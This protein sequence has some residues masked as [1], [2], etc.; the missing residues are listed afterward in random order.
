M[1][2]V[3]KAYDTR[4]ERD[5]AVKVIREAEAPISQTILDLVTRQRVAVLT[6][7]A[8]IEPMDWKVFVEQP[9]SEVFSK[10]A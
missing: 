6:S 4:L 5:V 9:V 7:V 8:P 10:V 3:Y 1:A 2:T